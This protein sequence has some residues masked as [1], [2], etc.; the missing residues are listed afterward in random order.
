MHTPIELHTHPTSKIYYVEKT[1]EVQLGGTMLPLVK[2]EKKELNII[3]SFKHRIFL[4][5]Y[6]KNR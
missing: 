2:K 1:Q 3:Q 5:G 4:Q 6:P